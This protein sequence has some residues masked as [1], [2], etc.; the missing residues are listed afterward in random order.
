MIKNIFLEAC[1]VL[2]FGSSFFAHACGPSVDARCQ[3]P[4][5]LTVGTDGPAPLETRG[6][7]IN[8]FALISN[9]LNATRKFYGN[10]LGM[11]HV[12][13]YDASDRFS[14]MY[15]SYAHGGKNGT[16]FMSGCE[17]YT[18][19]A[20]LDGLIEFIH[21]NGDVSWTLL[22]SPLSSFVHLHTIRD[23]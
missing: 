2:A 20:N 21:V 8:H 22:L 5:E 1:V 7:S 10:I 3:G 11:R 19:K 18:E 13:T 9:D 23:I 16:G 4:K 6:Y 15:M 14:L 17:L 12:F